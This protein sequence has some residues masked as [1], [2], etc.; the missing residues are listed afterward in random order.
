MRPVI[1]AGLF[2]HAVL[3]DLA[4]L[5][6]AAELAGHDDQRRLQQSARGQVFDQR[7]KALRR[8]R[9]ARRSLSD[10]KLWL[11]VSQNGETFSLRLSSSQ[12]TVTSDTPASTSRRA[13][14]RLWPNLPAPYRSRVCGGSL[15]SRKASL[16][17]AIAQ[18]RKRGVDVI[19]KR[20]H[21]RLAATA[22]GASDASSCAQQL[23]PR[24]HA[25]DR[26]V[27]GQ[28]NALHLKLLVAGIALHE[29][30]IVQLAHPPAGLAGDPF[31]LSGK[32]QYHGS[33]TA[34]GKRRA[35]LAITHRQ[36]RR[37][38]ANPRAGPDR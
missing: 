13:S 10:A 28:P 33:T 19:G 2:G 29:K 21:G 34:G 1:A 27:G 36:R 15:S 20:P 38:T 35:A 7:R 4:D 32:L 31:V 8:T 16:A 14:S 6:R 24:E 5:G 9:G 17:R 3:H 12:L 22:S 30:R 18:H 25:I 23:A 11:C 26:H 37:A